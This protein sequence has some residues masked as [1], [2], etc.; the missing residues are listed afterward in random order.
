MC[1][2]GYVVSFSGRKKE[3]EEEEENDNLLRQL[4]IA[5]L[6]ATA[7]ALLIAGQESGTVFLTAGIAHQQILF[8]IPAVEYAGHK[9]WVG[10]ASDC[11]LGMQPDSEII[12]TIP[13]TQ[14][15]TTTRTL[16]VPER[17]LYELRKYQ[18]CVGKS[19]S[20]T[21]AS[22]PLITS[23]LGI[24]VVNGPGFTALRMLRSNHGMFEPDFE[25]LKFSISSTVNLSNPVR[26]ISPSLSNNNCLSGGNVSVVKELTGSIFQLNLLIRSLKSNKSLCLATIDPE[27]DTQSYPIQAWEFSAHIVIVV[28]YYIPMQPDVTVLVHSSKI[29]NSYVPYQ[30][31]AG[32]GFDFFNV[33]VTIYETDVDTDCGTNFTT[34]SN[35]AAINNN[36]HVIIVGDSSESRV[37]SVLCAFIS[38]MTNRH[39]A[40]GKVNR[41]VYNAVQFQSLYHSPTLDWSDLGGHTSEIFYSKIQ[42]SVKVISTPQFDNNDLYLYGGRNCDSAFTTANNSML[43]LEGIDTVNED[44]PLCVATAFGDKLKIGNYFVVQSEWLL[45]TLPKYVNIVL[46]FPTRV[47]HPNSF[48]FWSRMLGYHFHACPTPSSTATLI[49]TNS[50]L[51]ATADH[52][53][54]LCFSFRNSSISHRLAYIFVPTIAKIGGNVLGLIND[55]IIHIPSSNSIMSINTKIIL[56]ESIVTSDIEV[57]ICL[58]DSLE[59]ISDVELVSDRSQVLISPIDIKPLESIEFCIKRIDVKKWSSTNISLLQSVELISLGIDWPFIKLTPTVPTILLLNV[60]MVSGTVLDFFF[61]N[62]NQFGCHPSINT[63]YSRLDILSLNLELIL[64]S[65]VS[66]SNLL[67]CCRINN[68]VCLFSFYYYSR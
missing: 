48:I 54:Q 26:I 50:S 52:Q 27:R 41:R 4:M 13:T 32:V 42:Y 68:L 47:V 66:L 10:I 15:S 21:D 56:P 62:S 64:P 8:T 58:K 9:V 16:E 63:S 24:E 51:I 28:P 31:L 53:F 2:F 20:A 1:F 45:P 61:G 55:I 18:L 40:I 46:G 5:L 14:I 3:K 33:E 49:D 57:G 6:A 39:V 12:F 22:A 7:V 30:V 36:S 59:K 35:P 44:R 29:L 17:Y 43:S 23:P 25:S 19:S 60:S 11:T 65:S 37:H 67:L 38:P 34:T